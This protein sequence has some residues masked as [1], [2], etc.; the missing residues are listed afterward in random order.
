[1][2]KEYSG[3]AI[4]GLLARLAIAWAEHNICEVGVRLEVQGA[5]RRDP[6]EG[7]AGGKGIQAA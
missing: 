1:M 5:W 4:A 2:E 6:G 3:L 7:E